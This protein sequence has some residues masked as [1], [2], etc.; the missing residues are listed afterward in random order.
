MD[1]TN[2]KCMRKSSERNFCYSGKSAPQGTSL[3]RTRRD[4]DGQALTGGQRPAL[5][6]R[7]WHVLRL[8]A[9]HIW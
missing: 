8:R 6:A 2:Q 4:G 7:N 1:I 3:T 9:S 5:L